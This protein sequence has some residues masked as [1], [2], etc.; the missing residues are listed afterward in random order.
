MA[1]FS[2]TP[3][4]KA[5]IKQDCWRYLGFKRTMGKMQHGKE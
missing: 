4:Y 2:S 1:K 5:M 3:V